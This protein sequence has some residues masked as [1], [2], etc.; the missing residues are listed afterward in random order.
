MRSQ[1]CRLERLPR[2]AP[3]PS[4]QAGPRLRK[5][6]RRGLPIDARQFGQRSREP[7]LSRSSCTVA[8]R[9]APA[10][11]RW[12]TPTASSGFTTLRCACEE[13]EWVTGQVSNGLADRV[14]RRAERLSVRRRLRQRSSALPR[15]GVQAGPRAGRLSLLPRLSDPQVVAEVMGASIQ[16]MRDLG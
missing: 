12:R 5:I 16:V 3:W 13:L 10:P 9:S 15:S 14:R 7:Q 6:R 8:C 4:N 2:L 11:R 1:P